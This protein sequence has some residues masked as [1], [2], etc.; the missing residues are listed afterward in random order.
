MTRE[1]KSVKVYVL[2]GEEAYFMTPYGR[3]HEMYLDYYINTKEENIY[4]Y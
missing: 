2:E 1:E 4:G 3:L